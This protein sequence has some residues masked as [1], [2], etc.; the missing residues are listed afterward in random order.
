MCVCVWLCVP[1]IVLSWRVSLFLPE[2]S[3]CCCHVYIHT[4]TYAD[5]TQAWMT[6]TLCVFKSF[7]HIMWWVCIRT[8]CSGANIEKHCEFI[9]PWVILLLNFNTLNSEGSQSKEIA[10]PIWKTNF[11][12]KFSK[13]TFNFTQSWLQKT[14]NIVYKLYR[15]YFYATVLDTD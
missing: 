8:V 4:H 3:V 7:C 9:D 1:L 15:L 12:L 13:E 6:A 11:A 2:M 5:F 14:W 10:H